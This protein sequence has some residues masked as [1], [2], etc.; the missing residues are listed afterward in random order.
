MALSE[1]NTVKICGILNV[2]TSILAEQIAYVGT[3]LTATVQ[4][5][6]EDQIT[7]W[8]SGIGNKTV[9]LRPTESNKGVQ[10]DP[11]SSR[12]LIVQNIAILLERPDWGTSGSAL[13][14]S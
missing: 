5:A 8:D 12:Q 3:R 9:K 4:T 6:I 13:E 14:R 1:T 10:T 2:T 7:L 11:G